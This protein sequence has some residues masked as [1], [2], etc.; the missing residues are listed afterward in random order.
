M[1]HEDDFNLAGIYNYQDLLRH[2]QDGL[3]FART[4]TY[5]DGTTNL[6]YVL[7]A[8]D[9]YIYWNNYGSSAQSA[10]AKDMKFVIERIFNMDLP[11]FLRAFVWV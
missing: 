10:T 1:K 3:R 11:T 9:R 2:L 5:R 6:W 4:I 8:D 7:R